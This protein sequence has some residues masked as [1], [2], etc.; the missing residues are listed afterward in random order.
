MADFGHW[1]AASDLQNGGLVHVG[2]RGEGTESLLKYVHW[3]HKYILPG[4]QRYQ[5]YIYNDVSMRTVK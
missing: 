5:R 1:V 2:S 4:K 3:D